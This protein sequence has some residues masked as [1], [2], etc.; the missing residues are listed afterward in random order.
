[1]YEN[2]A[3]SF[4][5]E[6]QSLLTVELKNLTTRQRKNSTACGFDTA[7]LPNIFRVVEKLGAVFNAEKK[8]FSPAQDQNIETT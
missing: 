5:R 8:L 6:K 1:M 3:V 7:F 2:L 4:N